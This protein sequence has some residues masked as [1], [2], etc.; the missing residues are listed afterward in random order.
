MPPVRRV[1]RDVRDDLKKALKMK[2][3]DKSTPKPKR[4]PLVE[5]TNALSL[6]EF[7]STYIPSSGLRFQKPN[8]KPNGS[9]STE[10]PQDNDCQADA[11]VETA[12]QGS[13]SLLTT[14]EETTLV[15]YALSIYTASTIPD[16]ELDSCFKLIEE[17]SSTAYTNSSMGWSPREKKREMKLPDMKYMILRQ[18]DPKP[19][20]V[21]DE[22]QNVDSDG[23]RFAGFISFMVTYEDGYEVLYC[24]EIHLTPEVQGQGL[25]DVL[26][27]RFE[28]IGRRVGL[29]KTMLTCFKSNTRAIRF[30]TR[31]GYA[32]DENSPRP[33]KLR[34]GTVKEADYLIMSKKLR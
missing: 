7:I 13:Q 1:S 31:I 32:E 11:N 8:K 16:I 33:R 3:S 6:E 24:Y 19:D 27:A 12:A 20:V 22:N 26:M 25:G 34:N 29:E 5:R 15:S 21:S 17:T 2:K 28:D 10:R 30:Y 9:I 4:L 18:L 14:K 23:G